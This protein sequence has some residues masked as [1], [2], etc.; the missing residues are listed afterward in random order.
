MTIDELARERS[1]DNEQDISTLRGRVWWM[2]REMHVIAVAQV[3]STL[4]L[5]GV[6]QEVMI[7]ALELIIPFV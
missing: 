5:L 7:R 2:T 1:H 6:S 3:I 4:K